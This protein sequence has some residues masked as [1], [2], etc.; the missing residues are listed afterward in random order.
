MISKG[1]KCKTLIEPQHFLFAS[2]FVLEFEK[3]NDLNLIKDILESDKFYN[4][5]KQQGKPW[6]GKK[7]YF[8]F[9]TTLLKTFKF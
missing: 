7:E 8:S 6:A 3:E 4:F 9:T 2:G 1:F 5:I